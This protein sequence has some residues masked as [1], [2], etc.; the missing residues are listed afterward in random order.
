MYA[1]SFEHLLKPSIHPG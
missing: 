1:L